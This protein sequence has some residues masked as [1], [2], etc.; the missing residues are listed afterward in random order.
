MNV[1][2]E[3]NSRLT[4]MVRPWNAANA[5]IIFRNGDISIG[6]NFGN[7]GAKSGTEIIISNATVTVQGQ[8]TGSWGPG[9]FPVKLQNGPDRQARIVHTESHGFD[10]VQSPYTL[11]IPEQA[12]ATPYLQAVLPLKAIEGSPTFNIDVTNW[13]RGKR[14]PILTFTSSAS[15][16][17]TQYGGATVKAYENGVDV[18]T[19]RNARL[20]WDADTRTLYYKQDA[21]GGF[22][23]IVK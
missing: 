19:K 6:G 18:T 23:L 12:Y 3:G 2:F 10:F 8:A 11:A 16:A 4:G 1:V 5:K 13:K 14:V 7:G 9:T 17:A 20:V 15:G 21:Q 22:A